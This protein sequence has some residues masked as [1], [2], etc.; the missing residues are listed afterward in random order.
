MRSRR[1]DMERGVSLVDRMIGS[2]QRA[3][4]IGD[5]SPRSNLDAAYHRHPSNLPEPNPALKGP[6]QHS[7]ITF[8]QSCINSIHHD[9]HPPVRFNL[10]RRNF[11]SK[12]HSVFWVCIAVMVAALLNAT[13]TMAQLAPA[14]DIPTPAEQGPPTPASATGRRQP[15]GPPRPPGAGR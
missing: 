5:A 11:M 2:G 6:L 12:H 9:L 15:A 7:C 3:S 13:S 14:A 10:K 4:S 8:A 1:D